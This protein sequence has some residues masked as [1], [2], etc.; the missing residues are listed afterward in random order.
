MIQR[1]NLSQQT[2]PIRQKQGNGN[3]PQLTRRNRMVAVRT[4]TGFLTA[5]WLTTMAALGLLAFLVVNDGVGEAARGQQALIN[6]SPSNDAL[7]MS[8]KNAVEL[9]KDA[10]AD[11]GVV[12]DL[13]STLA[14]ESESMRFMYTSGEDAVHAILL[15][16]EQYA[17]YM[18][19]TYSLPV[20][21]EL[22]DTLL[23]NPND[24]EEMEAVDGVNQKGIR[25]ASDDV[26]STVMFSS[27]GLVDSIMFN[28]V[29]TGALYT[30]EFTYGE[31]SG[32]YQQ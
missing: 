28:I 7:L 1:D 11:E 17:G 9:S 16:S 23:N 10:I 6:I 13:T 18:D 24:I 29:N 25:I 32:E 22:L 20:F 3:N 19:Y 15:P 21:F 30:E 2:P 31:P 27:N 4:P 14:T 26:I 5:M 12:V 8:A